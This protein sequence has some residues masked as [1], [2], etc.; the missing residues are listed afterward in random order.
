SRRL[1]L[2]VLE[3]VPF[4]DRLTVA[5]ALALYRRRGLIDTAERA[6]DVWRVIR[7]VNPA[8]AAANEAREQLSRAMMQ[9]GRDA[10]A[11]RLMQAYV[12]EIGRAAI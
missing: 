4:G 7:M 12:S 5:Q 8:T 10:I 9:W 2:L 11:R 3:R 6:Y 1:R